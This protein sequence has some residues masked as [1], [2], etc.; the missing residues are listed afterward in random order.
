MFAVIVTSQGFRS[1]LNDIDMKIATYL[2]NFFHIHRMPKC[3]HR[4]DC[5]N[6]SSRRNI[7]TLFVPNFGNG[8]KV[9]SQRL[10]VNP[11]GSFLAVYKMRNRIAISNRI[12]CRDKGQRG[13]QYFIVSPHL[14]QLQSNMKRSCPINDCYRVFCSC[15]SSQVLF[16]LIYKFSNRRNK[17]SIDALLYVLPFVSGKGWLMKSNSKRTDYISDR[18]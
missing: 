1:I 6:N 15:I 11:Q 9:T 2:K 13:N 3:M 12:R 5:T 4:H 17:T 8:N 7:D 14:R 10:R 16:K 18:L